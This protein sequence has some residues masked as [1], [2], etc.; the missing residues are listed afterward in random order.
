MEGVG[1]GMGVALVGTEVG[2][3]EV[4]VV[5]GA[6]LANRAGRLARRVPMV[7]GEGLLDADFD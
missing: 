1:K 7:M 2:G 5:I 6:A 3:V 4:G